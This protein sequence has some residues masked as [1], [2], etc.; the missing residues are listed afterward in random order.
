MTTLYRVLALVSRSTACFASFIALQKL[1]LFARRLPEPLPFD[2]PLSM[3]E[4]QLTS[5]DTVTLKFAS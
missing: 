1:L 4:P 2:V 3:F 5:G